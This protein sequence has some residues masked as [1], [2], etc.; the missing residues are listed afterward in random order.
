VQED[1]VIEADGWNVLGV[2]SGRNATSPRSNAQTG[3][4]DDF[5][6]VAILPTHGTLAPAV[7]TIRRRGPS[8][9]RRIGQ[10]GSVFQQHQTMWNPAASAYGRYWL[11]SPEGWKRRVISL[12]VCATRTVARR[13]LREPIDHEGV[14][15]K[16]AFISS[17][18]PGMTFREQ[19]ER[20]IFRLY[21]LGGAGPSNPL[22]FLAGGTHSTAGFFQRWATSPLRKFPTAHCVNSSKQ[23]RRADSLP[24]PSLTTLRSPR[25]FWHR[26]STPRANRFTRESGTTTL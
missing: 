11:D 16:D 12:G 14:N 8:M 4:F 20:W 19:A 10:A 23:W 9:A 22:P 26:W 25:W 6:R 24:K 7:R 17:T 21:L 18:T 2:C 13:K 3:V 1:L 5:T 15:N